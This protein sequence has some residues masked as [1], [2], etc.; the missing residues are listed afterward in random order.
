MNA[1]VNSADKAT[2]KSLMLPKRPLDALARKHTQKNNKAK[3]IVVCP[4]MLITRHFGFVSLIAWYM[5]F[6]FFVFFA[7]PLQI[8]LPSLKCVK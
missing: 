6:F 1:T 3:N 7:T 4:K 2:L 8:C 5:F